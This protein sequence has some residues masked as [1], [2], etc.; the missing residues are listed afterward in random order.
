MIRF[1]EA[2][3]IA[4]LLQKVSLKTFFLSLIDQLK[5][6]YG[7]W[8]EFQKSPRFASHFPKGVIELMPISDSEFYTFKY[9]NGHPENPKVGK[10]TVIA[11]GVLA[12]TGS[13]YP[14]MIAEMTLLTALRTAATSALVSL[15]LAPKGISS[16]GIIGTGAQSEFQVLAHFFALGLKEVF[17]FDLD[18]G[19]MEKFA[20]NLAPYRLKLIP[21]KSAQEVAE[22]SRLIT[23]ATAAKGRA[24][25][26]EAN[27]VQPGTH[28]NGIG[29]DCPGKTELDG[30]LLEKAKIVVEYFPQ[31]EIEGEI[32]GKSARLVYA[33]LHE[34][35]R[36]KKPAR[37]SDNEITLFDSVGF[38]LEDYSALR[39]L[40]NLAKKEGVGRDQAL[41][42][43][44]QNPKDL[45]SLLRKS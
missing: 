3:E 12:E 31:T 21:C 27:W 20:R 18:S 39:L 42:P 43:D 16:C 6:D 25:I 7:R 28:I 10:Q 26:L 37:V 4:D 35:V 19:A 13:G 15:Y 36:G 5:Q 33:E 2:K 14:L 23:T 40:Y 41:F 8:D 29:G 9:V 32:Q 22:K 34:L 38:A 1:L 24:K 17:Y 30:H 44:P 45:F 11:F